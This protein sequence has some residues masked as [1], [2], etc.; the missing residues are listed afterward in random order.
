MAHQLQ[1]CQIHNQEYRFCVKCKR[2]I[3][4]T[5]QPYHTTFGHVLKGLDDALVIIED[6][7]K[8]CRKRLEQIKGFADGRQAAAVQNI[9]QILDAS[10]EIEGIVSATQSDIMTGSGVLPNNQYQDVSAHAQHELRMLRAV[11]SRMHP[12]AAE[13]SRMQQNAQPGRV[14]QRAE[15][16]LRE[17]EEWKRTEQQ[18]GRQPAL[19]YRD[20]FAHS[21]IG[22]L[23][24]DLIRSQSQIVETNI[25][26]QGS[27]LFK[28]HL[29]RL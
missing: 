21:L 24:R 22:N 4:A 26:A 17:M 25:T 28:A 18:R 14:W 10:A 15:E 19:D 27:I 13:R 1:I 8:K 3:C 16:S 7:C 20:E 2:I 5:C 12:T 9:Q 6:A 29:P 23:R 11:M